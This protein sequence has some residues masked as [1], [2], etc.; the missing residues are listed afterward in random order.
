VP[1]FRDRRESVVSGRD[2]LPVIVRRLP[3]TFLT[4]THSASRIAFDPARRVL[5]VFR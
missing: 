2:R 3:V 4:L 1:F 5:V